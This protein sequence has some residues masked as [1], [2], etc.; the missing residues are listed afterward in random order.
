MQLPK[1]LVST[2]WLAKHLDEPSLRIFDTTVYL[3]HKEGGGYLPESGAVH[4]ADGHVPGAV[5]IDLIK[6]LSDPATDIPFMMPPADRFAEILGEYGVD[7]DSA[8][9][10]YNDGFPMWATRAWW[11]LR[12]I[13]FDNTAVLD[14]GWGK[15]ESEE[16]PISR[17]AGDYPEG[18]LS[19]AP[20]PEFWASKD[21]ML[22]IVERGDVCTINALAPAVY[23]GEKNQ[24]GR[25][26]HIP[27]SH[28]IF[29]GD[30]IDP[31]SGAFRAPDDVRDKFDAVGALGDGRVITYCGGGISATM[32]ALMLYQLGQQDVA[33]YDGSMSEWIR[34]EAL[35]L[36]LGKE[37]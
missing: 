2:D 4:Y 29:Y 36:K 23:T 6:E 3:K 34:D 37:P 31:D 33:V 22:E 35:P 8:V 12:S 9:V 5:F 21:D 13:G 27:G 18:S 1:P 17:E 26:G 7:D 15:W 19:A 16:R 28:N 25:P 10:F 14:G 30:L 24:Y 11:M 32:D 20:R